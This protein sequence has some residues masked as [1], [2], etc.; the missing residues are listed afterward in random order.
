MACSEVAGKWL[1]GE[2]KFTII[3]NAIDVD[4]F[5]FNQIVRENIRKECEVSRNDFLIG[6]VGRFDA[7]KNHVFLIEVF[8]QVH[9]KCPKSKLM[10]IGEGALMQNIKKKIIQYKL[11]DS[12][13]FTGSRDDANL[14]YNSFDLFVLPSKFEG[15]GI[16]AIEAEINGCTTYLSD[17]VPQE[18][19]ISD[20][21][22]YI[23]LNRNVWVDNIT[24]TIKNMTN[25]E[26][27][28]FN[29]YESNYNINR[30]AQKL[31]EMYME[32]WKKY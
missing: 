4:K 16:V 5:I 23:P 1:F 30:E 20:K 24:Q 29:P 7:Q 17:K 28:P 21:T 9:K 8:K 27:A 10:L 3:H 18:A 14:F 22:I 19:K 2:E 12:V 25:R 11:Q 26:A 31:Q 32:L 13:I 6:H 15:L